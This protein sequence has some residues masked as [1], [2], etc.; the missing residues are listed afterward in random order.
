[1][2]KYCV[3]YDALPCPRALRASCSSAALFIGF[4]F[5][6]FISQNRSVWAGGA[7]VWMG[8]SLMPRVLVAELGSW[9]EPG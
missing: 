2:R 9:Q 8:E 7:S 3:D 1:M 4:I 5:I 6:Y